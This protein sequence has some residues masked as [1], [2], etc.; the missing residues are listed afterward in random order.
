MNNSINHFIKKGTVAPQA[1]LAIKSILLASGKQANVYFTYVNF[2]RS[3]NHRIQLVNTYDLECCKVIYIYSRNSFECSD[4]FKKGGNLIS[5]NRIPTHQ[6]LDKY[7][8][9][10]FQFENNFFKPESNYFLKVNEL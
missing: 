4:W 2:P 9:K 7:R 3:T 5:E 8:Q 10:G 1:V 6:F